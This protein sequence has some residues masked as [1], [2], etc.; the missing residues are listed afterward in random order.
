MLKVLDFYFLNQLLALK[1]GGGVCVSHAK[2]IGIFFPTSSVRILGIL[3][4]FTTIQREKNPL[5]KI[6]KKGVGIVTISMYKFFL[7]AWSKICERRK[8]KSCPMDTC[9]LG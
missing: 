7:K 4:F 2:L 5:K 3:N 1:L 6:V 8:K 9:L